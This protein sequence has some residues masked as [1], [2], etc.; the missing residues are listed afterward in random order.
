MK[1]WL[2]DIRPAPPGW[3]WAKSYEQGVALFKA[4]QI[5]AASLDHD[6][7]YILHPDDD[8]M[9]VYPAEALAPTGYDFAMF[10]MAE[11]LW[12]A[13]LAVHSSNPVGVRNMCGI[14]ERYG[15]YIYKEAVAYEYDDDGWNVSG[16]KYTRED[17]N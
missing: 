9:R 10:L 3:E 2:D 4:N 8:D 16:V 17:E 13:S 14:I 7:G 12:P 15:N 5:E 11:N 1:I 6:L